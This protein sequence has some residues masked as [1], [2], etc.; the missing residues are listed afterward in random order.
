[1]TKKKQKLVII[2]DF[3]DNGD[4]YINP[5]LEVA[6]DKISDIT[7]A[8]MYVMASIKHDP[9]IQS[10]AN[11][12]VIPSF[13]TGADQPVAWCSLEATPLPSWPASCSMQP[14]CDQW[15]PFRRWGYS[16]PETPNLSRNTSS[17]RNGN[18]LF[19]FGDNNRGVW[20]AW[21]N[22]NRA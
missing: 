15:G 20:M 19:F 17:S 2:T 12:V 13:T 18:E 21:V 22:H 14:S 10:R 9:A 5:H 7:A 6:S 11:D 16:Q 3:R 8:T 1:M 4:F